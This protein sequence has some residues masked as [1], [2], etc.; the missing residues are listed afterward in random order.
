MCTVSV[1]RPV[2][3]ELGDPAEALLLRAVVNRDELRTRSL[4]SPPIVVH[5]GSVRAAM[6]VDPDG[7]GTWVAMND[8]GLIFALLNGA[9]STP[10]HLGPDSIPSRGAIIPRLVASTTLDEAWER[11]SRMDLAPFRPCRI[12]VACADGLLDAE[13]MPG[14]RLRHRRIFLP[15]RFV[16]ASSSIDHER[17]C[18][19]RGSL[20]RELAPMSPQAQDAFHA[21]RWPD[22]Q[23]MSVLMSRPDACTVSRTTVEVRTRTVTMSYAP[24]DGGAHDVTLRV[25]PNDRERRERGA[26]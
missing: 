14:G 11:L 8:A 20:F 15:F 13:R 6:P 21:H 5:G 19:E 16:A 3:R 10:E 7:R 1:I 17:A 4:A 23:A 25:A 22:R 26:A 12:I 18:E 2:V 24:I 9:D